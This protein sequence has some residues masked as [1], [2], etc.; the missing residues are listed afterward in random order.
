MGKESS[1]QSMRIIQVLGT[2][3]KGTTSSYIASILTKAG[4]KTGLYTSPHLI[5]REERIKIDGKNIPAEVFCR[6]EEKYKDEGT[7]F[8]VYT[9][10]CMEYFEE[11]KCDFAVLECGLGGKKDPTSAYP[12]E[13]KV[14]VRIGMDHMHILGNTIREIAVE[15]FAAVCSGDMNP[16]VKAITIPQ[17]EEAMLVAEKICREAGAELIVIP[18]YKENGELISYKGIENIAV[19]SPSSA[20]RQNACLAIEAVRNLKGIDI[21]DDTIRAAI[22][23]F[24]MPGRLQYFP[25]EDILIDGAHNED[26]LHLLREILHSKYADRRIVLLTSATV[27]KDVSELSELAKELG[28]KV[29]TTCVVPE[30]NVSAKE[31]AGRFTDAI[32]IEDFDHAYEAAKKAAAESGSLLLSAGSLYLAGAVLAKLGYI[33]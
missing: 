26:S 28:A 20:A 19:N 31:L 30:R 23:E 10:V 14:F 11:E 3:G 32:A 13:L 9:K 4:Y 1:M 6:L 5:T 24:V 12:A 17:R 18:P 7:F 33:V 22:S 29:Y 27:R 16:E 8:K 2:N 25:K 21:S 15:K